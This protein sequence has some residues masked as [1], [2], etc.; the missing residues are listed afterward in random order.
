MLTSSRRPPTARGQEGK[1]LPPVLVLHVEPPILGHG[2][3]RLGRHRPLQRS[4]PTP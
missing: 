4:G 3:C 2:G 1:R